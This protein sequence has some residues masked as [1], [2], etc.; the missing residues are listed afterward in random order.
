[1]PRSKERSAQPC[2]RSCEQSVVVLTSASKQFAATLHR[3]LESKNF[4]GQCLRKDGEGVSHSYAV[5]YMRPRATVLAFI[6]RAERCGR[7]K[8]AFC[9]FGL[10]F[11]KAVEGVGTIFYIDL[12]CSQERKGKQI[13]SA[14]ERHAATISDVV[15]LRAATPGLVRVY[16]RLGYVRAANACLPPSRAAR[17]LLRAVD[18]NATGVAGA[19]EG[20][21]TDGTRVVSSVSDAWRAVGEKKPR[22]TTLPPGWYF[23][24][25]HHGWYMSKCVK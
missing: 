11:T 15:A 7:S 9:G 8:G 16:R 2:D 14:L 20:V 19:T 10:G 23:E 12:V 4:V 5:E 18:E 24:H 6:P 22:V 3:V 25:G 17:A 13:L 1:M 21:Y